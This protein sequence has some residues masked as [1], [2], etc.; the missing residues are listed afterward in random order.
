MEGRKEGKMKEGEVEKEIWCVY[1]SEQDVCSS[2]SQAL[3]DNYL[4]NSQT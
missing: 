2:L 1:R 4:Q 3:E